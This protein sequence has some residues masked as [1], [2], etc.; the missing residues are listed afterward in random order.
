MRSD[1]LSDHENFNLD[2]LMQCMPKIRK[3]CSVLFPTLVLWYI[4][5][6]TK[7]WSFLH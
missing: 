6:F 5:Q 3:S 1:I 7:C 4:E 2:A